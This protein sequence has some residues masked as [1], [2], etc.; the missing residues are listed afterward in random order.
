M[1]GNEWLVYSS[2]W[3]QTEDHRLTVSLSTTYHGHCTIVLP[4]APTP[5]IYR[6]NQKSDTLCNY[7]DKMPHKLKSTRYLR[8]LNNFRICY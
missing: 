1:Y 5:R 4:L 8:C 7:V 2:V 3:N 6:V